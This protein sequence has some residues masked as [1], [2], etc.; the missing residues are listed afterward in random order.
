MTNKQVIGPREDGVCQLY[1]MIDRSVSIHTIIFAQFVDI[2]YFC[3]QNHHTTRFAS[4]LFKY[5]WKFYCWKAKRKYQISI[6]WLSGKMRGLLNVKPMLERHGTTVTS[7][8]ED[9]WLSKP[10]PTG[11]KL[12]C[13]CCFSRIWSVDAAV[14]QTFRPRSKRCNLY[15]IATPF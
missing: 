12:N 10:M 11:W 6:E 2:W 14:Y 13:N 4:W 9:L 1:E 15:V 3:K 5:A 8:S 7:F